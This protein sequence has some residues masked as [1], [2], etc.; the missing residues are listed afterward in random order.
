MK[1][2]TKL[3]F[4]LATLLP[5]IAAAH[6]FTVN[7]IYYNIN[8]N[9]ATVTYQ[10]ASATE[11]SN[12]YQGTVVIPSTVNYNGTTYPVTAIGDS[13]FYQSYYLNSATIGNNVK[14]IG[15]YA[16]AGCGFTTSITIGNAVT[17]IGNDAFFNC[18]SLNNISI[19]NSV[20]TIERYAFYNCYQAANLIIGNSVTSIGYNAFYNCKKATSLNIPNS[21]TR[22]ENFAFSN[23]AGLTSV[24]IGTGVTYLGDL[25]FHECS[26]LETL[27]Y[28]AIACEDFHSPGGAFSST[29]IKTINIGDGVQRIPVGFVRDLR[30]FTSIDI[31]N[32]VTSIGKDAFYGCTGLTS[33]TLG[34]SVKI[35]DVDAFEGCSGL[36]TVDIPNSVTTIG[37]WAFNGCTALTDVTIGTGVTNIG[38]SA[39]NNCPSLATVNY[40]AIACRYMTSCPFDKNL[41][42]FNIGDQVQVIPER[43]AE[44]LINLTNLTISNSVTKIDLCAFGGCSG[45]TDVAFGNSV[46]TIGVGAFYECSGLT[47]LELPNSV[48]TIEFGAFEDCTG[49][50]YVSFGSSMRR[51]GS[52]VFRNSLAIDTVVCTAV[53]PPSWE[54]PDVFMDEVYE[55]APL[56]VPEGSLNDYKNDRGKWGQFTRIRA[57]GIGQILATSIEMFYTNVRLKIGQK[58]QLHVTI[59]PED[60]EDQRVSW[61]SSDTTVVSVDENGR[62]TALG[63]GTAVVTATTMDGSNLSATCNFRVI[64]DP[65]DVSGDGVINIKDVTDLINLLLTGDEPPAAADVNGDGVVSI[66][67]VTDLINTLL[68]SEG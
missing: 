55:N 66:K 34:S 48:T 20:T 3:L 4:L 33:L 17:T 12:E 46:D 52:L 27:N 35:I 64:T 56:Y 10:G 41:S 54:G 45:L 28:N 58:F 42:T 23:C 44:G 5:T 25:V 22:I 39:F 32:S 14:V 63:V 49:L 6:D 40:N 29:P 43:T 37:A 30:Q 57:I 62:V 53:T 1:R 9:E 36:T 65:G 68:A 51:F 26:A 31:P 19:P 15:Q 50:K 38:A 8:G 47:R 21:V 24:T 60:T 18:Y 7:G 61:S 11:V 13:A 67:D 16:F 59:L 2:V